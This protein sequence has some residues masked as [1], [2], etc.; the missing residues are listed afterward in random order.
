MSTAAGQPKKRDERARQEVAR[1]RR[2]SLRTLDARAQLR[3]R[4]RD[5]RA[6][7]E[8]GEEQQRDPEDLALESGTAH[9]VTAPGRV[10]A[11]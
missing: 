1:R 5:E 10:R 2:R 7:E 9:G 4:E 3:E 8:D 6:G 11:W